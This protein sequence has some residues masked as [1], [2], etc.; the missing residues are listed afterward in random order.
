MMTR[1]TPGNGWLTAGLILSLARPLIFPFIGV[2]SSL[3]ALPVSIFTVFCAWYP[4]VDYK[5]DSL[6][7]QMAAA[8]VRILATLLLAVN[9]DEILWFGNDAIFG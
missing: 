1:P 3:K 4:R 7:S 2:D 5:R 6:N 9:L 8:L